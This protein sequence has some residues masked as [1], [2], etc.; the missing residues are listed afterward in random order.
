MIHIKIS[1][2][3]VRL[4]E[5]DGANGFVP[6]CNFQD[7]WVTIPAQAAMTTRR[8]LSLVVSSK[9]MDNYSCPRGQYSYTMKHGH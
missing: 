4:R 5:D 3:V 8:V 1:R 6:S 9:L 2:T 7:L